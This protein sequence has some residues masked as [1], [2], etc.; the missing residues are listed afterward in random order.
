MDALNNKRNEQVL[1]K[2][3][4]QNLRRKEQQCIKKAR[5]EGPTNQSIDEEPITLDFNNDQNDLRYDERS[6]IFY[7]LKKV[8]AVKVEHAYQHEEAQ[9]KLLEDHNIREAF[10]KNPKDKLYIA[11]ETT[12]KLDMNRGNDSWSGDANASKDEPLSKYSSSKLCPE[13]YQIKM[14]NS[15]RSHLNLKPPRNG[16][17][18][19]YKKSISIH[20]YIWFLAVLGIEYRDFI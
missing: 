4:K 11:L 20:A 8:R 10:Q 18:A 16:Q 3:T 19:Q 17:L 1:S 5:F 13:N 6:E 9:N 2:S 15:R 14:K 12:K 7:N